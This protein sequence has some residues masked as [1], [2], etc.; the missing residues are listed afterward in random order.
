MAFELAARG[1]ARTVTGI[2]PAG[3]WSRWTPVKFEV[4]SKFLSAAPVWLLA[5]VLGQRVLRLPLSRWLASL[6]LSASADGLSEADLHSCIDDVQHCPA[7][8]RLLVKAL[9]EPGLSRL[10]Q[11]TVPAHLV[12]CT[13]DR[14][15]PSPRFTRK[16]TSEL[17]RG[18]RVSTLAGGHVPMFEAPG[19]VTEVITDFL[20]QHSR[21]AQES[22]G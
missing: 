14:V 20:D 13:K 8:Y 18:L 4:I 12:N 9:L 5:V 16:F 15:V 19:R 2:A 7:Y 21:P 1:R 3:G 6:P 11:T 10:P 17:P 22:T